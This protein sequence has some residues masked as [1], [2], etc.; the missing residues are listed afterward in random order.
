MVWRS[1]RVLNEVFI[2]FLMFLSGVF[3]PIT[4]LPG[5][6]Q[7]LAHF[8]PLTYSL[9]AA[10]KQEEEEARSQESGARG[11]QATNKTISS[12]QRDCARLPVGNLWLEMNY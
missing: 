4:V 8:S 7:F 11:N 10:R 12:I 6:L 1:A 3:Y 2:S 5:P 9:E